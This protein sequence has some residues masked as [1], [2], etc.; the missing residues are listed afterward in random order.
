MQ[1]AALG[2]TIFAILSTFTSAEMRNLL[3]HDAN[4][5]LYVTAI[6]PFI[7]GVLAIATAAVTL[8]SVSYYYRTA[9][10]FAI[11]ILNIVVAVLSVLV[12]IIHGFFLSGHPVSIFFLDYNLLLKAGAVALWSLWQLSAVRI[13]T[14]STVLLSLIYFLRTACY[15]SRTVFIQEAGTC[16]ITNSHHK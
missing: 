16:R 8:Y 11:L 1:I 4:L 12:A 6:L 13:S 2:L 10:L 9:M 3:I 15:R 7:F 5:S 14:Q